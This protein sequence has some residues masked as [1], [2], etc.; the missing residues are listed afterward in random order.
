MFDLSSDEEDE[1][2]EETEE[3]S[4]DILTRQDFNVDCD[5]CWAYDENVAKQVSSAAFLSHTEDV[6]ELIVT[7]ANLYTAQQRSQKVLFE[8]PTG[9]VLFHIKTG[10]Q[11][12]K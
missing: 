3:W 9:D 5:V 1:E 2:V 6:Y 7:Q 8:F 4:S 10:S 11:G 12:I